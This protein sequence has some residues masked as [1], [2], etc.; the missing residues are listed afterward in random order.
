MCSMLE[1]RIYRASLTSRNMDVAALEHAAVNVRRISGT[2]AQTL[3]RGGLV[4]ERSE[5]LISKLSP[6][7]RFAGKQ[8]YGFFDFDGVHENT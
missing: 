3:D 5:K 8:G 4:A 2:R 1:R 6:I 7:E